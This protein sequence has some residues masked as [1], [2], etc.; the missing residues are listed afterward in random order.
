MKNVG[1]VN[2][3]STT[4]PCTKHTQEILTWRLEE[5]EKEKEKEREKEQSVRHL[6][7]PSNS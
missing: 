4:L 5:K 6:P 3:H 7:W 1:R 2:T